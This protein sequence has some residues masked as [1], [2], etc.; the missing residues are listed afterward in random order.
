MKRMFYLVNRY[1]KNI[2]TRNTGEW[3]Q[4]NPFEYLGF[5]QI[6][7]SATEADDTRTFEICCKYIIDIL[8]MNRSD[9]DM[10]N[11]INEY[12]RRCCLGL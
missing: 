3:Y 9:F 11:N 12:M 6:W 4:N 1:E 7:R 10:K 8:L 2:L 5:E